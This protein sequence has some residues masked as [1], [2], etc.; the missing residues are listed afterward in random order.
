MCLNVVLWWA[1]LWNLHL[2]CTVMDWLC[3]EQHSCTEPKSRFFLLMGFVTA[4]WIQKPS[5]ASCS[6]CTSVTLVLHLHRETFASGLCFLVMDWQTSFFFYAVSQVVSSNKVV[7]R[8]QCSYYSAILPVACWTMWGTE[9]PGGLFTM[10]SSTPSHP[11]PTSQFFVLVCKLWG[12]GFCS[13]LMHT[14][15]FDVELL[16]SLHCAWLSAT[17]FP[18]LA[19]IAVAWC[20]QCS[21]KIPGS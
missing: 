20:F 11:Q 2:D 15:Y 18:F 14:L 7:C 5:W 4:H 9:E 17:S 16:G 3:T 10:T 8:T 21:E 6:I 13:Y 12:L 19:T 1:T